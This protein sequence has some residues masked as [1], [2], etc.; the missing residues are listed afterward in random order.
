M[1]TREQKY[2]AQLKALG[3]Y[4]PAFEPELAELCELE[5]DR[6]RIRKDWKAEG[7]PADSKLLT[8]LLQMRR[9]ILTHRDALGL[10]PKALRRLKSASIIP[11]DSGPVDSQGGSPAVSALLDTLRAQAAAN[12][13]VSDSD[14][15]G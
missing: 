14:R 1:P 11:E 8:L 6:Q 3:I 13:G 4:Q 5:R 12:A 7:S 10:T 2:R 15:D 9:D